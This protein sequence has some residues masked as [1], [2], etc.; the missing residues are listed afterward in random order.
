MSYRFPESIKKLEELFEIIKQQP[1]PQNSNPHIE[2]I[3]LDSGAG[4]DWQTIVIHDDFINMDCQLLTPRQQKDLL[5]GQ[6][7]VKELYDQL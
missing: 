5:S 1:L 2:T 3:S 6:I 4:L 7:S